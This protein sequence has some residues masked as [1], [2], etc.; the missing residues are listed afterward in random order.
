MGSSAYSNSVAVT[1]PPPD[2]PETPPSPPIAPS[3]VS[4]QAF[5]KSQINVSWIN[6]GNQD[7]VKIERCLGSGCTNFIE[8]SVVAGNATFYADAGLAAGTTFR[9]RLRAYNSAGYSPYSNIAA[10]K[11]SRR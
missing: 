10:A 11:T 2:P 3:N 1:L 7:G 6:N 9:Y 4:A 8:I 5:G